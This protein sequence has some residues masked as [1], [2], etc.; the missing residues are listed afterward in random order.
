MQTIRF[1]ESVT[2]L[3]AVQAEEL[4]QQQNA[5]DITEGQGGDGIDADFA[6]SGEESD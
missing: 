1:V 4:D 3:S 6:G 2:K 5:E